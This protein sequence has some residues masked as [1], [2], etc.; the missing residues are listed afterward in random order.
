MF[1]IE[2]TIL[3]ALAAAGPKLFEVAHS[4]NLRQRPTE[5]PSPPSSSRE[6][7]TK[8]R[9]VSALRP[10]I[11]E[12]LESILDETWIFSG[13]TKRLGRAK[14]WS[15]NVSSEPL[16]QASEIPRACALMLYQELLHLHFKHIKCICGPHAVA[17]LR[18]SPSKVDWAPMLKIIATATLFSICLT[19]KSR[20]VDA[21]IAFN[22]P[23]LAPVAFVQFCVRYHEDCKVSPMGSDKFLWYSRKLD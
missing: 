3:I 21:G 18:S 13:P 19:A 6:H 15:P 17:S 12:L 14:R 16:P 4:T 9:A 20:A 2:A 5:I 7:S 8:V 11:F 10:E 23:V 1:V 22:K